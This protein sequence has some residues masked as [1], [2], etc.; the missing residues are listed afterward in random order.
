MTSE[1]SLLINRPF[2]LTQK[3]NVPIYT[4][5]GDKI[6]RPY[7]D[8]EI[9]DQLQ[10]QMS[11]DKKAE[12]DKETIF[13]KCK[14]LELFLRRN[15]KKEEHKTVFPIDLNKLQTIFITPRAK[16]YITTGFIDFARTNNIAILWIDSTG[17]VDASF[18]P[19][20]FKKSSLV[21]KQAEAR[22]NGKS[23]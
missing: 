3:N 14:Y 22:L 17:K 9:K 11:R 8:D 12:L 10:K 1:T 7:N 15:T 5:I 21:V 19:F 2:S 6:I 20:N 16:G 18:F 13:K 23:L 4:Q